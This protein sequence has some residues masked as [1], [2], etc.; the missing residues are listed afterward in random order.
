MRGHGYLGR[1]SA[2]ALLGLALALA[3]APGTSAQGPPP[4][5]DYV[6][7]PGGA[8]GSELDIV[9]RG[10][11]LAGVDELWFSDPGISAAPKG[12]DA[13]HIRIAPDAP[14]GVHSVQAAGPHGLSGPRAFH[15][16]DL[17]EVAENEAAGEPQ[18]IALES[19]VSGAMGEAADED[20]F[21]VRLSRGQ[22][23]FIECWARRLDARWDATL[24]LVGPDRREA[25]WNRDFFGDDPFL[26]FT[27]ATDG[28]HTIVLHDFLHGGSPDDVYRLRVTCRPRIDFAIPACVPSVSVAGAAETVPWVEVLGRGLPGGTPAG[29]H[30]LDGRP[31]ESLRVALRPPAELPAY[32]LRFAGSDSPAAS[33]IPLFDFALPVGIHSTNSIPLGLSDVPVLVETEPNDPSIPG[34]RA[35]E[36]VTPFDVTGQFSGPADV[37]A[38]EV[39]A[40]KGETLWVETIARRMGSEADPI[41]T[42]E[43]VA[44]EGKEAETLREIDDDGERLIEGR[45][46]TRSFDARAAWNVPEDGRYRLLVRDGSRKKPVPR[47]RPLGLF[48]RLLV[49]PSR[50]DFDLILLP[51]GEARGSVTV[52]RGGR[53]YYEIHALRREGH[54]LPVRAQAVGFPEGVESPGAHLGPGAT[55]A[56]LV[57]AA[58]ADAPGGAEGIR[59]FGNAPDDGRRSA[60]EARPYATTDAR[61][62]GRVRPL[63]QALIWISS[64]PPPFRLDADP[65][66]VGAQPGSSVTVKLVLRRE[67]PFDGPVQI[68]LLGRAAGIKAQP[69]TIEKE[70]SEALVEIAIEPGALPGRYTLAFRGDA[71][72]TFV[73]GGGK[74]PEKYKPRV[75]S[76][77]VTLDVLSAPFE[78]RIA[79]GGAPLK[80]APG[81][82]AGARIEAVRRYGF[83]GE[84]SLALVS[85]A[86]WLS[87]PGAVIGRLGDGAALELRAAADAPAGKAE[88]TVRASATFLG[89]AVSRETKVALEV[90]A[91]PAR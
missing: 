27:A 8:A 2:R 58:G 42:L 70:K 54:A 49:R 19:T 32:R 25:A 11:N 13:F 75:P 40:K 18:A 56:P 22:R 7:P 62:Q 65:A 31:L 91:A 29:H 21:A 46:D 72:A 64:G 41:V 45:F 80:L 66:R 71:E 23:V 86:A 52:P 85:P 77:A 69:V 76:N 78:V 67:P 88:A 15:V 34:G 51:G 82:S 5:L 74:G 43:R 9:I 83:Q 55:F 37:D 36:V 1:A 68:T 26:D 35:E 6:F 38:Y 12:G 73:P 53:G 39:S 48:Y 90:E 61:S 28:E 14:R 24:R 81:G 63:D 79:G 20:R 59:V 3:P 60:R 50:P 84:V 57:F 16:D 87:S 17:T 89:A 4:S 30:W 47:E 33:T 44:A 10:S